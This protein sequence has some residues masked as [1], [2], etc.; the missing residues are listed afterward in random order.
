MRRRRVLATLVAAA[1]AG[2]AAPQ[3]DGNHT[4]STPTTADRSLAELGRPSTICETEPM[5][6][7]GIY[8]IDAPATAPDWNGVDVDDRYGTLDDDTVV[9]GVERDGAARAYPLPI[10]WYH[11]VVND[12][13]GGPLLVTYCPICRSAMV[14]E[15]RVAGEPATFEVTGKLWVP[16]EIQSRASEGDGRTFG[17]DADTANK[18]EIRNSGNVVLVDDLTGSYWSQILAQAICGP[19]EGERLT[20][21]P[22]SVR[23]WREWRETHPDTDVLLPPPQSGTIRPADDGTGNRS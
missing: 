7:P 8:A 13:L 17:V 22:A 10:V 6:D 14:A 9:I 11:E 21:V 5:A 20:A 16:P 23:T 2:C 19:Q 4:G 18:T 1:T 12:A 3:A 15:R